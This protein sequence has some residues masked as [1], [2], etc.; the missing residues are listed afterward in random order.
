MNAVVTLRNKA[1]IEARLRHDA[2]VHLYEI[3]DLDDFFFPSCSYYAHPTTNAT[4]LFYR[5]SDPPTLLALGRETSPDL[6]ELV[7]A[8]SDEL[9]R[10]VYAH[11]AVGLLDAIEDEF[12]A[13]KPERHAKF[14]LKNFSSCS[15]ES[16]C[17]PV[18]PRDL[19]AVMNLYRA[20]YPQTWFMPR[21]LETGAYFGVREG[22][23][24]I[25]IAGVH[26]LS[27]EHRVAVLGNV[28]THPAHR[29]KGLARATCAAVIRALA[30]DVDV[31]GLNVAADNAA[32]IACYRR[33]GF[34]PVS[35]YEEVMLQKRDRKIGATPHVA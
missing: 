25:A 10:T 34:E 6:A 23:A 28:A 11:L 4:A 29:G 33:L 1:A 13:G 15:I 21:M 2:A 31:V 14:A 35:E 9:P 12:E 3:G 18:G 8:I 26:V 19:E 24:W 30:P 17:E 7:H 5:G 22:D 27:R 16:G 20:S 32:A